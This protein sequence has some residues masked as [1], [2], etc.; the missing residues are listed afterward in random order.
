MQVGCATWI[1]DDADIYYAGPCSNTT[2]ANAVTNITTGCSTELSAA[3]LTTSSNSSQAII[4]AVQAAYPTVRQVLCLSDS[5]NNCVTETLTNIQN[6]VGQLNLTEIVSIIANPTGVNLP[7]NVTCT[8]CTKA[9]YNVIN[10]NYPSLVS[11]EASAIE[12]Q[13][14]S[15]FTGVY[16][17]RVG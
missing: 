13:C 1:L 10:G 6:V 8:N 9:A 2:L 11:G 7:A 3:G 16:A 4:S 5:G 12:S 14:G 17:M 15:S